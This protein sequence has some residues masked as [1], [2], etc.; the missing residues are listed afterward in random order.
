MDTGRLIHERYRLQ[1]Q[2]KQGQ[3]SSVYTGLDEVL[4]RLVTVK[5]VPAASI[6][7]YRAA[8][9]MTA[10]FS[11]P[12]IVGLYDL[13]I[14]PDRLYLIQ[15]YI[16]GE[17]FAALTQKQLTPYAVIDIG[18]QLC[19][20]LLYA[21]SS[22]RRVSHGDLT[23]SA[24]LLDQHGF[25]RVNNFA[26]PSDMAYFQRWSMLGGSVTAISDTDLPWGVFSEE[27]R[28]DD[29]RAAGLLLYQLLAS[30]SNT[31][32]GGR[33]EPRPDGR[34]SFQRNVPPDVCELVARAVARQHPDPITTP[35]TLYA[36][37]KTL[38]DAYERSMPVP[39]PVSGAMGLQEEAVGARQVL[40]A[41][42]KLATAL[43]LRDTDRAALGISPYFS[44]QSAQ[45]PLS[46]N[47]PSAPTVADASFK[48]AA[49]R[50]AAYPAPVSQGQGRSPLLSILL[51][52]LLVFVILFILGY[53]AGQFLIPH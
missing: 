4:S 20:A 28:A 11:H 47:S 45:L 10:H 27:R 30:R 29:T 6:A 35:E 46:D 22:T 51:I 37:L 38:A 32:P 7:F 40:P 21:G 14:E 44:G 18:M 42:G 13:I 15:E 41:G 36:E 3:F 24:V 16:E 53:F 49:A 50:R 25:V 23:P 5:I 9:K 1:R 31:A 26:L 39:V 12:N 33:V 52:C 48:L 19:Q 34:L 2:L 17:D 8:M 43:P